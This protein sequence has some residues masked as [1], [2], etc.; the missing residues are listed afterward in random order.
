VRRDSDAVEARMSSRQFGQ[1][2]QRVVAFG[3]CRRAFNKLPSRSDALPVRNARQIR[4]RNGEQAE[5]KGS[6]E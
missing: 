6:N 2:A 1:L 3:N 5:V 4:G